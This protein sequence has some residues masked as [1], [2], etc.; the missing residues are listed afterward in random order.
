MSTYNVNRPQA[1]AILASL[2]ADGFTLIQGYVPMWSMLA[3]TL[4][5]NVDR[6]ERERRP[7]F[8]GLCRHFYPGVLGL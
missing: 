1:V 5:D 7:R 3:L 2:Q 6:R 4:S 8:V